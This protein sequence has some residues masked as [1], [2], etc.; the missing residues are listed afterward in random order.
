[1][2]PTDLAARGDGATELQLLDRLATVPRALDIS[3]TRRVYVN[4]NL[5][6]E[7]M[8]LVGFD[9]D[10][11]LALY[12]QANLE[13]LSIERTLAKLVEKRRYPEEILRLEYDRA[14]AVRGIVVDRHNGNVAKM[15][16]YGHVGRVYHGHKPLPRD[17]RHA[18]YRAQRVRLS[19]PRYACIDTLFALP[20]ATMYAS[21]VDFFDGRA[22]GLDYSRLWQDIRECIDEAHREDG[23]TSMKAFIRGRLG[24]YIVR[25]PELAPTLHKLRSAGKRLFLLTNSAWDYTDPVMSYLLDGVLSAYPSWRSYFDVIVVSAGKPGFF[26]DKKPFLTADG[27]VMPDG[28]FQRGQVYAGG[29]VADFEARLGGG[30]DRVLYIGDHIYGD[31][32]RAKKSSVWRTAMVI[33][34]LEEEIHQIEKHRSALTRMATLERQ[35]DRLDAEILF[36]QRLTHSLQTD[37]NDNHRRGGHATLDAAHREARVRL[38]ELRAAMRASGDEL[39]QLER[40]VDRAFNPYWGQIFREGTENSRFGDQVEE[41]ACV[42]TSRVSNFLA[43]S[44]VRYFRSPRDHMPHEL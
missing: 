20:E 37:S 41:Y 24:E 29:H 18:L 35:V 5:R 13:K 39:S 40:E 42:Y 43:Y 8:E 30:G 31:M 22:A 9:M 14:F 17:E 6:M 19:H 21:L 34:E 16:R 1:M 7:D 33:Q 36:Q 15:D 38:D 25:D 11:T 3:A 27:K 10:Y 32:L 12:H 44:P 4:R 23:P 28:P 2:L 26:V